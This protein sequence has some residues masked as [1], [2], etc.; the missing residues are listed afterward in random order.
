LLSSHYS[1]PNL[2]PSPHNVEHVPFTIG[3]T[4]P[5]HVQLALHV[6]QEPLANTKPLLHEKQT[7]LALHMAQ[8]DILHK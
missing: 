3:K 7:L 1:A 6:K 8:F 4:Q 2:Y 5:P